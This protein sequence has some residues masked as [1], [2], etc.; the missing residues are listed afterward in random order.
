MNDHKL[1]DRYQRHCTHDKEFKCVSCLEMVINRVFTT[2]ISVM[3]SRTN[4]RAV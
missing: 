2:L 1:S 3:Y 4:I